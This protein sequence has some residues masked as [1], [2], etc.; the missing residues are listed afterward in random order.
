MCAS[1]NPI[2]QLRHTTSVTEASEG[3]EAAG[4]VFGVAVVSLRAATHV[5]YG[6]ARAG[7]SQRE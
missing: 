6:E 1:M 7:G 4:S 3:G 2:Q 5:A